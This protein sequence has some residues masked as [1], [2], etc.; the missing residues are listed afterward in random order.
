MRYGKVFFKEGRVVE[1]NYDGYLMMMMS[2]VLCE[3]NVDLVE[4]E[5]VFV[6]VGEIGVL[7]FVFVFCNVIF[8]VIG[9]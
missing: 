3:I 4:S 7:F 6:G 1:M 2:D 9:I 5:V 8:V